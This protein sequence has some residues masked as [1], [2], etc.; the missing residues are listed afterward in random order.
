MTE[1]LYYLLNKLNLRDQ[2]FVIVG[3]S[4]G[5]DSMALLDLLIK[6]REE[7]KINIV[8]AHINHNKRKESKEE[9]A[10]VRNFCNSN[11]IVFELLNIDI[12]GDDNFHNEARLKRYNFFI[13]LANRYNAKHILTAH[14]AD[15]LIE[16]ILMR[17][18]RGSSI[19]GYSGFQKKS[20]Y[21]GY[22][23][24]RPLYS[25]TKDEILDYNKKNKIKYFI[26]LSNDKDT[27]TRNRY[28]KNV[29]P[30]LKTED[31]NV[32]EK[33]EKFAQTLLE[34]NSYV[35]KQALKEMKS[36]YIQK[37]I[38]ILKFLEL[39]EIIQKK[40]INIILEKIYNDD[41]IL[42]SD[43]HVEIIDKLIKSDKPNGYLHLPND[44][45]V[46]K[47]Y[48]NLMFN[49]DTIGL[50]DYE[51]E[52]SRYVN[53]P[54][55]KNLEIIDKSNVKS[56][57]VCRLNSQEIKLPLY[58]RNRRNGDKIK[59]KGMLG[60]KKIKDIFIDEKIDIED[61]LN[62]PIL[63]DSSDTILWIPGLKKSIFDK[64]KNEIYDIIIKYY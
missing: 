13:E 32:H 43:V 60:S 5:P 49:K 23:I 40:I 35:E 15:D 14:H 59:I 54:N 64:E 19:K 61:R 31:I 22:S 56:N 52:L 34:Y 1:V 36:V 2:D 16:T 46:T 18:V 39:E 57:Y 42:I 29:L 26:D 20:D 10:Y 8:C 30:F 53:L 51:I 25:I 47:S 45:I 63:L 4:G 24:V 9:E 12:Y 58:V 27:Y 41:L 17:I 11:S 21:E 50:C 7:I 38:N 6:V 55:G 48:N 62:W 3:V 44:V 37:N 28:R 33:F